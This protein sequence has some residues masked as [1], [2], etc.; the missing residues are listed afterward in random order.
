MTSPR[1]L[2]DLYRDLRDRHLLVPVV[3]LV[4]GLVA[5]PMLLKSSPAAAPPAPDPSALFADDNATQPAV[6][7]EEVTV[8]DYRDRLKDFN[9]RNPFKQPDIALPPAAEVTEPSADIS[10]DGGIPPTASDPGV[11]PGGTSTPP[12]GT[13][14]PD[15][16]PE[17]ADPEP[18]WYSYRID[19][20]VGPAGDLRERDGVGQLTPLPSKSKPVVVFLGVTSNLKR[21]VFS[22]S[23]QVGATDGDGE[24]PPAPDCT[25]L[26]L[27]KGDK[28]AFEYGPDGD[29]FRL[30]LRDIYVKQVKQPEG[31]ST[32]AS[33]AGL[34]AEG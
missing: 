4:A 5:V 2:S 3:L 33:P 8:R 9:E 16:P 22:V 6:L 31:P 24:C 27:E 26:T 1:F 12:A 23:T 18:R 11:A 14:E 15:Q 29:P 7:A 21:A 28:Q 19:V 32:Q 13:T 10:T 17:Q 34:K 25:Y 30:K 20:S